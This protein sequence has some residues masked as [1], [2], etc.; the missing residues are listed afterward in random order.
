MDMFLVFVENYF[1]RKAL[2]TL[3]A[4]RPDSQVNRVNML[5]QRKLAFANAT[6]KLFAAIFANNFA[7]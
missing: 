6:N 4:L 3:V 2:A 1:G 5:L 7:L